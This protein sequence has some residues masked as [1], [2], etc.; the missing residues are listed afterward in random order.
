MSTHE[1]SPSD[2]VESLHATPARRDAC[3]S[4]SSAGQKQSA[5]A[6]LGLWMRRNRGPIIAAQWVVVIF[7]TFVVVVPAFLPLPGEADHILDNL[8]RFAQFLFWGI[9]WPFVILSVMTMGRAWC[10][11]FCPEGTLTEFVSRWSLNRHIPNWLKWAGWPFVAFVLTTLF[12][13]MVSVYEYPKPALLILGGSTLGAIV[14]GL[15]YGRNKRVWC[16]HLCPVSGVFALLAKVA[17]VHFAVDRAAW[18]APSHPR[19]A[20]VNCAPLID[21]RRM[22]SA[23]AC[24]MCGRCAGQRGAVTLS[25][26]SPEAEILAMRPAPRGLSAAPRSATQDEASE[27]WLARLLIFGMLGVALGAF[28][29]TVSPSFVHAK[30][31]LAEWLM[32]REIWWPLDTVGHWWLFTDYPEVNDAFTWLDGGMLLGYMLATTLIV[33]GWIWLCLRIAARFSDLPWSRL[34]MAMIPLG[35]ISVFVGLSHLTTGQLFQENIV[36]SWANPLRMTLLCAAALWS[37]T[38][39]WRIGR[40][41]A[42]LGVGCAAALPL[43][44]W[45]LQFYVW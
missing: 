41:P 25:L 26:R 6:R 42:A 33:G 7:Y 21:I 23:S 30:Q 27:T 17:P 28:Q 24:H 5:L 22:Q 9:W 4:A 43:W 44:A 32:D 20:P 12:G 40:W 16:R 10:G 13:Q 39:A 35:G 37:I 31:V 3:A 18:D 11:L 29:W 19:S 2:S 38:L 45:F 8:T 34:A 1:L 14:V 15:L 36:L